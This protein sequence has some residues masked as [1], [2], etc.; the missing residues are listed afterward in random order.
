M[1]LHGAGE[2]L[3]VWLS[4]LHGAQSLTLATTQAPQ[5]EGGAG[6]AGDAPAAVG[7][8][9][10]SRPSPRLPLIPPAVVGTRDAAVHSLPRPQHGEE[11]SAEL[12]LTLHAHPAPTPATAQPAEP[13]ALG[14]FGAPACRWLASLDI[15]AI[16]SAAEV[17]ESV[18]LLPA[19]CSA[20]QGAAPPSSG[21]SRRLREQTP[22]A[23]RHSGHG[24]ALAVGEYEL[25]LAE[26]TGHFLT[27]S[28][29]AR[30]P[31][32]GCVPFASEYPILSLAVCVHVR[33]LDQHCRRREDQEAR[34]AG[35]PSA[36][37]QRAQAIASM[38][39]ALDDLL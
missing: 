6:G 19:G 28:E 21:V 8:L 11:P 25:R 9:G 4:T 34:G 30:V 10:D 26:V 12:T 38:A 14:L 27:R 36:A 22:E 33:H 16:S 18:P 37:A 7:C 15:I 24:G 20:P 1:R 5:L 3:W 32:T 2:E 31:P 39:A 35:V 13:E 23:Q 17:H 29:P